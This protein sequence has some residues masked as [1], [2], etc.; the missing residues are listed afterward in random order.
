MKVKIKYFIYIV[1]ALMGL[2]SIWWFLSGFVSSPESLTY[3]FNKPLKITVRSGDTPY[4]I[5]EEITSQYPNLDKDIL[6]LLMEKYNIA[7]I[8]K[9]D[10]VYCIP[11]KGTYLD[12]VMSF[13]DWCDKA[14]VMVTFPEGITIKEMADILYKKTQTP[15]HSFIDATTSTPLLESVSA[16]AGKH[17]R[18]PEGFL[19]PD[20]YAFTGSTTRL[21]HMMFN[22]FLK[23]V[24]GINWTE[25]EKRTGLDKYGIITLASIVEKEAV[26]KEEAPIIA[27]V[28]INRLRRGMKLESCPTVEYALGYHKAVLSFEDIQIDSPYN[29]YKYYGLPPTPIGNP[30]LD[31]IKA[32][33]NYAKTDYLYFVADGKG[34]HLFAKTY[35]E[36]LANIRRVRGEK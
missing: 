28:F 27:G 15:T 30:S 4:K 33:I 16:F 7:K 36:H 1:A 24:S 18:Y 11:Q 35:A 6:L 17:I 8:L 9:A 5:V 13:Q 2:Y 23:K 10:Y 32:V 21:V 14:F 29:T 19:Y 12:I 22:N 3:T 20:T 31:A 25:A 26:K 34:G